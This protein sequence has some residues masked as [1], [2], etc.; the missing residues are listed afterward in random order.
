MEKEI[1]VYYY[2]GTIEMNIHIYIY[3]YKSGTLIAHIII[4]CSYRSMKRI[5]AL[6]CIRK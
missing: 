3:I 6:W 1:W 5:S 4:L 2:Y